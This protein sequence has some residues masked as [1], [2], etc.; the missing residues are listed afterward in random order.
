MKPSNFAE[1][2]DVFDWFDAPEYDY[3]THIMLAKLDAEARIA[4]ALPAI[5]EEA[6]ALIAAH[7]GTK[8]AYPTE[9]L[10]QLA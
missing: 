7:A 1:C 10:T 4:R 8:D 3:L 5:I 6:T 9:Y 2:M